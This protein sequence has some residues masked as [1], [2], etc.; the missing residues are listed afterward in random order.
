MRVSLIDS[1]ST[2]LDTPRAQSKSVSPWP[3]FDGGG[4][5]SDFGDPEEWIGGT[6]MQFFEP[7]ILE[8]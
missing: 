4:Q 2:F 1:H 5:L 3:P 6:C 7:E 8:I